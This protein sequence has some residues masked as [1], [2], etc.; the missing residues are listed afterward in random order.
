MSENRTRV[1]FGDTVRRGCLRLLRKR[2]REG[3]RVGQGR[4]ATSSRTSRAKV[5]TA[6]RRR[7]WPP[8]MPAAG[9]TTAPGV[10]LRDQANAGDRGAADAGSVPLSGGCRHGPPPDAADRGRWPEAPGE[11][12]SALPNWRKHRRGNI[13]LVVD[14]DRCADDEYARTDTVIPVSRD[15]AALPR[16]M[17]SLPHDRKVAILVYGED[18]INA[19]YVYGDRD[20][21]IDGSTDLPHPGRHTEVVPAAGRFRARQDGALPTVGAVNALSGRNNRLLG[22]GGSDL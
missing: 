13:I 15:P 14:V 7:A 4:A 16:G 22:D 9:A 8:A 20:R 21:R 1:D 11:L 5:K 17:I 12:R 19:A 6:Q 3:R 2:L 10:R 18:T